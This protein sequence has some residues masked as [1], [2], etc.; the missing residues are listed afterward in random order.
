MTQWEFQGSE[1]VNCN[2][3]YGCPCQFNDLPTHGHCQAI[4]AIAIDQ[5]HH[6]STKLDGLRF[7]FAFKWPGPI[8][9]G[10]GVCQPV[11]DERASEAQREALLRIMSGQDS[12]PFA[13]IFAVFAT[14]VETVHPPIFTRIDY[15]VD[16]DGRRGRIQAGE[17]F[18]VHG[19]PIRNPVTGDE[20]RVRIDLPAGFEYE[21]AE[22]GSGRSTSKG[23]LPLEIKNSYAQF[24]RLHLSSQGLVRHR[25]AA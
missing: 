23:A 10:K 17:V 13:T 7:G 22:I 19:E 2:C 9:E 4:G 16:V 1:L 21:L 14:T 18:E 6:G 5:G 3:N 25:A 20:H 15:Q 24:A 8:H 12:E 11:V